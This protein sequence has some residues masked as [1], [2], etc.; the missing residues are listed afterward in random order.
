MR[1]SDGSN[2]LAQEKNSKGITYA[3]PV[4]LVRDFAVA[5]SAYEQCVGQ[6]F[7]SKPECDLSHGNLQLPL[8]NKGRLGNSHL[9]FH[10]WDVES[11]NIAWQR[12][13]RP[14]DA[15]TGPELHS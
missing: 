8:I 14:Y 1:G 15:F 5:R 10:I 12:L 9:G 2:P 13:S 4:V 7:E 11:E 6:G 3:T